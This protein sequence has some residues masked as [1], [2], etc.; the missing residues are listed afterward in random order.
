MVLLSAVLMTLAC[1]RSGTPG[2]SDATGADTG[3]DETMGSDGET[4]DDTATGDGGSGDG[5]GGDEGEDAGP[6]GGGDA[7]PDGSVEDGYIDDKH[8]PDSSEGD[9]EPEADTSVAPAGCCEIDADCAEGLVCINTEPSGMGACVPPAGDYECWHDAD[10]GDDGP[11]RALETYLPIGVVCNDVPAQPGFCGGLYDYCCY[12]DAGCG[13]GSVCVGLGSAEYGGVCGPAPEEGECYWSSDCA[14]GQT[15]ADA[16]FCPCGYDCDFQLATPGTC[17]GENSVC[18][19]DGLACPEGS[20]CV[21]PFEEAGVCK[22][23]PAAGQCWHDADCGA[24]MV[25]DGAIVCP[26]D[27]NCYAAD[28]LGTCALQNPTDLCCFIDDMCEPGLVC[29]GG[30]PGGYP[31]TCLPPVAGGHCWTNK[32]CG[33]DAYCA[34]ETLCPC[35]V[36]CTSI[37]GGCVTLQG[38]CCNETSDCPDNHVCASTTGGDPGSCKPVPASGKCWTSEDCGEDVMCVGAALCQCG[39]DCDWDW[40]GP[41]TCQQVECGDGGILQG[42]IG[43]PCPGGYDDCAGQVAN[44]CSSGAISDPTLPPIC[45]IYCTEVNPCPEGSSCLPKGWSSI[46]VPEDC[47]PKFKESCSANSEC[48]IAT[49]WGDCC[50]CPE[51]AT[52]AEVEI[53]PCMTIGAEPPG[54][55]PDECIADC[56]GVLCE[57]CMWLAGAVCKANLCVA[58]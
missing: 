4:G 42:G 21:L 44:V 45:T 47:M 7:L 51:A 39:S 19:A 20:E 40:E 38:D 15:C 6:D 57:E 50:P 29:A 11:C 32:D 34:N 14:P 53:D 58:N 31:G 12:A 1:G 5:L 37:Q 54:Y 41:G 27:M 30:G 17:A 43:K 35:D 56:P 49:K 23:L 2:I 16:W 22:V 52:L 8:I 28:K 9:V 13:E 48:V 18:C 46:C 25:C 3:F 33:E 26:C 24:G 36:D 55:L 10:C